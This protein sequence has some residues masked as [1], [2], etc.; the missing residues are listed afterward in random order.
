VTTHL[1][2]RAK[3][4]HFSAFLALATNSLARLQPSRNAKK[5]IFSG[6]RAS[7]APGDALR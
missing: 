2:N 1:Q 5:L 7:C 3:N 6:F 4:P